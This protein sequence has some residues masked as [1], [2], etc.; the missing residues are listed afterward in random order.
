MKKEL[1]NHKSKQFVRRLFIKH[2][3]FWETEYSTP[4]KEQV[5]KLHVEIN[6]EWLECMNNDDW[7]WI[8]SVAVAWMINSVQAS[9]GFL[10]LFWNNFFPYKISS[11]NKN[12]GAQFKLSYQQQ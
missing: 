4:K 6:V 3:P 1:E 9:P 8:Y 11:K 12:D 2:S 5:Y 7:C 10:S